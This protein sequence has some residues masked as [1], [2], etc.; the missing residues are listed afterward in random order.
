MSGKIRN[1][2]GGPGPG[3]RRTVPQFCLKRFASNGKVLVRDRN[4]GDMTRRN[5]DDLAIKDYY[6]FV[7]ND[8]LEVGRLED[9]L[10]AMDGG[11]SKLLNN[12]SIKLLNRHRLGSPTEWSWSGIP[13]S[14]LDTRRAGR[15]SWP[16]RCTGA[17]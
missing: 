10:A 5:I 15:S 12:H 14:T 13:I 17:R 9:I 4:S 11:A 16:R 6:T 1:V 2:G 7:N 8:G 3:I